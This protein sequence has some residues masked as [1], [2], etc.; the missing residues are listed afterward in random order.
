MR[1]LP[2]DL[3]KQLENVVVAACRTAEGASRAAIEGLGVF[4][5]LPPEH[6]DADQASLRNGLRAKM[7]QLGGKRELL[8]AECAYEQWHRLLFA[9]F[10]AENK[11]PVA[12][13][14]PR[15]GPHSL[16]ARSSLA[17]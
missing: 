16:I 17:N 4:T 5:E 2:P 10:L 9:R 7:R 13:G 8:I 1:A 11:T 15:T 12:S 3:R 14:V 6:L